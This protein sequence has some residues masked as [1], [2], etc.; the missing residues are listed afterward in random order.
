MI[1]KYG[2]IDLPDET[3]FHNWNIGLEKYPILAARGQF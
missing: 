1:K 2:S 3:Y